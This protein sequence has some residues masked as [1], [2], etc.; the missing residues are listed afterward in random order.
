VAVVSAQWQIF[1]GG[2]S[3]FSTSFLG[4]SSK[5]NL[6]VGLGLKSRTVITVAARLLMPGHIKAM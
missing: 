3:D 4:L 1:A 5:I 6:L 2:T